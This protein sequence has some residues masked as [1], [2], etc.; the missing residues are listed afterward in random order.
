VVDSDL[1]GL[2]DAY[3]ETAAVADAESSGGTTDATGL[4]DAYGITD[5][6]RYVYDGDSPSLNRFAISAQMCIIIS[7]Q[8][9]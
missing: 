7:K 2:H 9:V 8:Q 6:V 1:T 3:R 4:P 5:T